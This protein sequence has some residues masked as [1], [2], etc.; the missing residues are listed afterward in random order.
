M[1]FKVEYNRVNE[2]EN[3]KFPEETR[4]QN[5]NSQNELAEIERE[6]REACDRMPVCFSL[7]RNEEEENAAAVAAEE[8]G[9][10]RRG[11]DVDD[12]FFNVTVD[13]L[14]CMLNDLKR[15][16]NDEAPLMTREMREIEKDKRAMKYSKVAIRVSFKNG[17][18]LQVNSHLL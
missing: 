8:A 2:F 17:N 5:L 7:R 3:F 6:S 9:S 4:G 15:L 11:E 13:D 14:R 10:E 1:N 16:Q 12:E 18:V